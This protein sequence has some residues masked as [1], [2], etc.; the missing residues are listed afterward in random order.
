MSSSQKHAFAV[1]FDDVLNG[2]ESEQRGLP[3]LC[4]VSIL[5]HSVNNEDSEFQFSELSIQAS[6]SRAL[7]PEEILDSA[8]D[9]LTPS[10]SFPLLPALALLGK[11]HESKLHDF[12][13][14][15]GTL[16]EMKE[17][18]FARIGDMYRALMCNSAKYI[19]LDSVCRNDYS[20]WVRGFRGKC[21]I[22]DTVIDFLLKHP[23]AA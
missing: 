23:P 6:G 13:L 8:V 21:G 9:S 7:H 5:S 17:L 10:D 4:E 12:L 18:E 15:V 1:S 3:A 20:L 2:C 16:L 14:H 19:I 22:C 11:E